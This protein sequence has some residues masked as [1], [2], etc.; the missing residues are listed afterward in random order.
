MVV[1]RIM[2]VVEESGHRS[3]KVVPDK[4]YSG[5]DGDH[6]VYIDLV[7]VLFVLARLLRANLVGSEAFFGWLAAGFAQS[8]E[9]LDVDHAS[10]NLGCDRTQHELHDRFQRPKLRNVL[11][12]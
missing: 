4:P 6:R 11:G 5:T 10:P 3:G 12:S 2:V 9:V 8:S 7:F 1:T